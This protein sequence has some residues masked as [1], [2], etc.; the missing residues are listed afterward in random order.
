MKKIGRSLIIFLPIVIVILQ[1]FQPLKNEGEVTPS[2]LYLTARVPEPI[3]STL[4]NACMDC[5]SN[6]TSYQWYHRIS[7]ISWY[8]SHHITEGKGEL[9]FSDWGAMTAIDQISALE[10]IRKEVEA[11]KMPLKSYQ[12]IHKD[13][14]LSQAQTDSLVSW[15]RNYQGK[16][17]E[18]ATR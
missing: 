17:A 16:L 18:E 8:V 11:G 12:L 2:H 5:H 3:Q 7:P 6:H 10:D 15:I 1:F 13:A 14:R 4:N 9:N